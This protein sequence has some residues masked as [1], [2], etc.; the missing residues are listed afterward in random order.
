MSKNDQSMAVRRLTCSAMLTAM[1]VIIG[2]FCKTYMNFAGGLFRVT[3]ENMPIILTG[4]LFGPAAG[5]I[6]GVVTD[7]I[8]MSVQGMSLNPIITVGAGLVGA[9]SGVVSRYIVKKQGYLKL[10]LSGVLAHF[11]GSVIV[12]SI[13]LYAYYGWGILYRIPLYIGIASVEMFIICLMYKNKNFRELF[14]SF[15]TR[16]KK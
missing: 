5:A 13:G 1:S 12:K 8:G 10:I 16:R 15:N 7:I 6:S 11:V 2:L 9:V 3:F 4:I 14:E